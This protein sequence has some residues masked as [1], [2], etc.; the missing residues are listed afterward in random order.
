MKP[1]RPASCIQDQPFCSIGMI[2]T[3]G[4]DFSGLALSRWESRGLSNLWVS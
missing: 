2:I 1:N 4:L 3:G